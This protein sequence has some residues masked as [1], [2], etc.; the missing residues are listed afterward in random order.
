MNFAVNRAAMNLKTLSGR[1]KNKRHGVQPAADQQLGK[2]RY[3][4]H[5]P[6]RPAKRR[7]PPDIAAAANEWVHAVWVKAE[8]ACHASS[9]A[10]GG[11]K[12]HLLY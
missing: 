5:R 10:T 12:I 6:L 3:F 4:Q 8:A 11:Q 2:Y 1:R 7:L 9:I